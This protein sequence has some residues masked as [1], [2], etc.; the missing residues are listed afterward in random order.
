[1]RLEGCFT[2]LTTPFRDGAICYDTLR[3]LVERQ[4]AAGVAGVVP[5]GT[6]GESPTLSVGEHEKVIATVIEAVQG[7]CAVI[8]GTGGNST[9]E[10]LELTRHAKA[11][12]ADATLQVTPYYNKPSQEGLYGHFM[13]V[14]DVGLPVMLYSI[15]GRCHVAIEAETVGRLA[16][17]ESI[18]A[19][20]EA[21]GSVDRVSQLRQVC[22]LD[23]LSGDDALALPMMVMGAVGVVSVASNLIP[24][25]MV[26][27]CERALAGAYDDARTVH[28]QWYALFQA[29]FCET[30][31][32]PVKA[33][34]AAAGLHAGDVRL[35]LSHLS[36]ANEAKLLAVLNATG[37]V[38]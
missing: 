8:A 34:M 32:V 1:M 11:A 38:Q 14:A 7:R 19:I 17:H 15:P 2:A 21:G 9:A 33:A 23:I 10:A 24:G 27:L 31:P 12:G 37:L 20:K 16:N 35:P 30:N 36:E 29:L 13:A 4:I 6:T 22:E 26:A 3:Q 25:P 28:D 18:V 5:V